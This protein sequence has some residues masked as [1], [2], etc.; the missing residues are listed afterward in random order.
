[1]HK[2]GMQTFQI[3]DGSLSVI[4]YG[5]RALTGSEE[6]YLSSMLEFLTLKWVICDVFKDYLFYFPHFEIYTDLTY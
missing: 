3:Q 4:G 5:S 2:I 1:M 6:K